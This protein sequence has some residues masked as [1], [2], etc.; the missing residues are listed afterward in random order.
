MAVNVRVELKP[1]SNRNDQMSLLRRFKR[2]CSEAGIMHLIKEH[3]VYEKPS[4]KRRRKRRHAQ[5]Q[6]KYAQQNKN[7]NQHQQRSKRRED[8]N[9]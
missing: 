7:Q 8:D 5:L 1:Y 4:D 9:G 2:A 6:M 3:E